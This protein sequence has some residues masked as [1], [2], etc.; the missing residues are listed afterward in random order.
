[1]DQGLFGGFDGGALEADLFQ[2]GP[3]GFGRRSKKPKDLRSH[4][5]QILK[6]CVRSGRSTPM[7][8]P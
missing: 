6:S 4:P 7:T 2:S 8:F 5:M 3:V 1:M